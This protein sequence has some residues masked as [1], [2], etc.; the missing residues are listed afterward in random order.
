MQ[1]EKDEEREG[2]EEAAART[3]ISRSHLRVLAQ[4]AAGI[5]ESTPAEDLAQIEQLSEKEGE[6]GDALATVDT[7]IRTLQLVPSLR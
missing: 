2:Q 1:D 5:D 7:S 6:L 4:A 3:L